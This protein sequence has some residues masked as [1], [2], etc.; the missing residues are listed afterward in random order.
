[1]AVDQ[2][3]DQSEEYV[4]SVTEFTNSLLFDTFVTKVVTPEVTISEEEARAYFADHMDDFS[5]PT[6]LRM[7]GLAF[8]RLADAESALTKL[9]RG[10]DFKWVSANSPG[11][12]DKEK[13]ST[14]VFDKSLL[15]LTSLP[16]ALQ[17]AADG[18]QAG[19]ALLYESTDG[20]H[21][22]VMI[23]KVFPSQ[24]KPYESARQAIAGLLF[25]QKLRALIDDWSGK[26]REAY[27]TRIF[28]KGLDD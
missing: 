21:H 26:L 5:S 10:A 6:M 12:I 23:E 2:G 13:E 16:E 28:L 9:R 27:E 20:L 18:A 24:P 7:N 15:S 4:D 19:D 1:V 3:L 17:K 25:E 14:F 8:Y 11:Q 22:V